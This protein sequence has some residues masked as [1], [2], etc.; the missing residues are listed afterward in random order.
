MI[1]SQNRR[2]D[3]HLP[4]PHQRQAEF[5]ASGVPR[6]CVRAGR[7]GGKTV[8][9]SVLA[10]EQFLAGKRILYGAPTTEHGDC[11]AAPLMEHLRLREFGFSDRT[12]KLSALVR[13]DQ[14]TRDEAIA[15]AA[16]FESEI[17]E[18]RNGRSR[19]AVEM[20]DLTPDEI[21]AALT[22]R[23]HP[24]IPRGAWLF[25]RLTKNETM[26]RILRH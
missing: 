11:I 18:D 2:V 6:K 12:Q 8:G 24:F 26:L 14:M 4:T 17:L 3:V 7:R 1:P 9:V 25:D 22:K 23:Q 5:I 13:N 16:G 10:V 21:E 15:E 20:L 19:R